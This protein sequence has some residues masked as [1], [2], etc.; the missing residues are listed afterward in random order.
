MSNLA[1]RIAS[2]AV[3]VPLVLAAVMWSPAWL[4]T[5]GVSLVAGV[6]AREIGTLALQAGIDVSPGFVAIGTVALSWVAAELLG[7]P[8][9]HLSGDALLALFA[10]LV[11]AA[12]VDQL[13]RRPERRSA[14]AWAIAIAVPLYVG[15]MATFVIRLRTM[16]DSAFW[17]LCLLVLVWVNDSAAYFGGRALGKHPM[18]PALSPKKTWEGLLVGTFVTIAVAC[19][20]FVVVYYVIESNSYVFGGSGPASPWM[21]GEMLA[22]W[23]GMV[24]LLGAAVS[25]AGPLGDLS[26]SFIKRQFGAKDSS[27]V[28]PGHGGVWDRIDSLLFA[29][30]VVYLFAR[31]LGV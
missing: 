22:K 15:G 8:E 7:R 3:M 9:W 20:G 24:A 14:A 17:V 31:L 30:P 13:V 2:A 12:F 29:A 21:S 19:L 4:W 11:V 26:H 1:K 10:V 23:V 18:A 27:N 16:D 5:I 25:I 6:A 28:I